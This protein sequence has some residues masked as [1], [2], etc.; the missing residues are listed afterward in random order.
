MR[1]LS[2]ALATAVVAISVAA[3]VASAA[4]VSKP[5]PPY[6][7]KDCMKATKQKGESASYSKWHCDQLVKKGWVKPPKN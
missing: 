1:R 2:I 7:Y 6:S 5:A 3:P 4:P